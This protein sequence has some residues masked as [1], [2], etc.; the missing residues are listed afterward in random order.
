MT[1]TDLGDS[2]GPATKAGLAI[3]S[4]E[5]A[6]TM[7]GASS[8][9]A[10]SLPSSF[11]WSEEYAMVPSRAE[12]CGFDPCSVGSTLVVSASRPI[13]ESGS[14]AGG[15]FKRVVSTSGHKL[16]VSSIGH[17]LYPV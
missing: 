10:Q 13:L 4:L 16:S 6:C 8:I 17:I 3:F 12:D 15:C 7:S 1:A 14:A 5:K 2:T 9:T 11:C